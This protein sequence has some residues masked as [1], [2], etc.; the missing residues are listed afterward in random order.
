[1]LDLI[2]KSLIQFHQKD[3]RKPLKPLNSFYEDQPSTIPL[4]P[5]TVKTGNLKLQC[6][7]ES[8]P[9]QIIT[10][11]ILDTESDH[12]VAITDDQNVSEGNVDVT[13]N[14]N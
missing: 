7:G 10:P 6:G 8:V 9:S 5:I 11:D 14:Y 3:F 1:M 4:S 13:I 12:K 2:S